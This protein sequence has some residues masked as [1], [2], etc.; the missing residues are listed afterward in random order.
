MNDVLFR[1][2]SRLLSHESVCIYVWLYSCSYTPWRI[3]EAQP[4]KVCSHDLFSHVIRFF[5]C[6]I[7]AC[8]QHSAL[9]WF[10][11][12]CTYCRCGLGAVLCD[13]RAAKSGLLMEQK[14]FPDMQSWQETYRTWLAQVHAAHTRSHVHLIS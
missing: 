11:F 4:Q 10:I 13:L 6:F 2:E 3:N 1:A 12:I 14:K 7:Q 8:K 5:I 9:V